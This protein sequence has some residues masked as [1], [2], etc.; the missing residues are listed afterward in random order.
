MRVGRLIRWSLLVLVVLLLAAAGVLYYLASQRPANYRPA[1]LTQAQ[2][3]AASGRFY[4]RYQDLNNEAQKLDAFLF[5]IKQAEVNEYLA[6]MDEIVA[7]KPGG[8]RGTVYAAMGD[9]GVSDP[10]VS[11]DDGVITFM[12]RSDEYEKIL[13][14]D[15]TIEVASDE[16]IRVRLAAARVG[17]LPLPR[18][19]V[20]GQLA[21]LRGAMGG[22]EGGSDP[23]GEGGGG[24]ADRVAGILSFLIA[25][26]DGEPIPTRYKWEGHKWV[27]IRGVRID[28]GTLRLSIQPFWK[29]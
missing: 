14:M 1:Q 28:G 22:G 23:S 12:I 17:V 5:S 27:H 10:A 3:R 8:R 9:I 21:K 2:K 6:S 29:D 24:S 16:A 25:A 7:D 4:G 11:L 26:M 18:S 19:L 15:V 13:S 20:R